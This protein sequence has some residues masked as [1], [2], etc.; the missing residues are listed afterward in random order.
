MISERIRH[1]R[2][3]LGLNQQELAAAAH[4]SQAQ[5]SRYE[6]G[7]NSPTGQ[8]LMDLARALDTTPDWLLGMADDPGRPISNVSELSELER[9]ALRIFRSKTPDKQ[10]QAVEILK[11]V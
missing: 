7:D 4:V 3:Q 2:K 1:R 10:R 5:I 8:S 11:A 6:Q 9:E